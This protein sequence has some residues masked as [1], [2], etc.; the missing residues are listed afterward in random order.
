[1][2]V[3]IALCVLIFG[4]LGAFAQTYQALPTVNVL[5]NKN[6]ESD[7]VKYEISY[8]LVK[9]V[10]STTVETSNTTIQIPNLVVGKTYYMSVIAINKEGA[11]SPPSSEISVKI[12]NRYINVQMSVDGGLT[13][14]S[15][16]TVPY[17]KITGQ[18]YKTNIVTE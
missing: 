16:G 4:S 12:Y 17:P 2:R 15:I 11:K 6:P 5:W 10:Y 3:L 14:K 9:G 1:M 13:Y 18:K 7:V 8:G